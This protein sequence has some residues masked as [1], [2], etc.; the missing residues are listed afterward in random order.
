MSDTESNP[1]MIDPPPRGRSAQGRFEPRKDAEKKERRRRSGMGLDR[2]RKLFV[3]ESMKDPR[4]EYRWINDIHGR[5][6]AKTI[7]DD[8]DIC[9]ETLRDG[10]VQDYRRH[11]DAT[12]AGV[13]V[14]AYLCRKPKELYDED[15]AEEQKLIDAQEETMRRGPLPSPQ[16]AGTESNTTYVPGGRNVI[17][18]SS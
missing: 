17:T 10:T 6:Q 16:G 13:P 1:P 5:I 15:K 2:S 12:R 8:W 18:K 7:E 3:P 14:Y 9:K 4:Y 11:A